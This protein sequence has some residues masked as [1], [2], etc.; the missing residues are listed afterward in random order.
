MKKLL[1]VALV[2]CMVT[3][4]L[5]V[6][7]LAD[8]EISVTGVTV[9]GAVGAT[10]VMNGE[11]LQMIATVH[12]DNAS[13]KTV[14]WW[15][16]GNTGSA[17]ISSTGLLTAVSPGTVTVWAQCT[18]RMDSIVITIDP[19]TATS[20]TITGAGS[21][22]SVANGYTLQMSAEVLP[23]LTTNK[24]VSWTLNPGTGSATING[25]T[26]LLKGTGLGTVTVVANT[27]VVPYVAGY[28][29]VTVTEP[30]KVSGVTVTGAGD[31]ASVV[32]YCTLQM[33]AAVLPADATDKSCTWSVTDSGGTGATINSTGLLTAGSA[34]TVTVKA[35]AND[36]S[37]VSGELA[38]TVTADA[39]EPTLS[40]VSYDKLTSLGATL[41]FSAGEAGT[42][43]YL[44]YL[45]SAAAPDAA[46]IKS[47]GTSGAASAGDNSFA[48]NTLSPATAY[49]VYIALKDAAGN[50]SDSQS[51]SFT[52]NAAPLISTAGK[53][54][55]VY[56]KN[57][58]G[59]SHRDIVFT[60]ALNGQTFSGITGLTEGTNYTVS[61]GT[62]TATVTLLSSYLDGLTLWLDHD[63]N[64]TFTFGDG[65]TVTQTYYVY[66]TCYEKVSPMNALWPHAV[67]VDSAGNLYYS[68]RAGIVIEYTAYD[69]TQWGIDMKA[70]YSYIIAQKNA[71]GFA[72]DEAGNLYISSPYRL[73]HV[74][75]SDHSIYELA[76]ADHTQW[77]ITMVAGEIYRIAGTGA[78]GFSGDGGAAAAAQFN[79][80]QGIDVDTSGNV[81][82]CDM[83]NNRVRMIAASTGTYFG[84]PMTAG[85]IYTVAGTGSTTFSGL[86]PQP[87][88]VDSFFEPMGVAVDQSGNIY[89]TSAG[90][91][92]SVREVAATVHTQWGYTDMQVGYS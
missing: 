31:A 54:G 69:H 18:D 92:I 57:S 49:T 28:L 47:A 42:Y 67:E 72:F 79:S 14:Y 11:T 76:A 64:L 43:Y 52:T 20:V 71:G 81:Y 17:T 27:T 12:P 91:S 61:A 5:P 80:P 15:I 50:I 86:D 4:L 70:G 90:N 63:K 62:D 3:A 75:Y 58:R 1:S 22:K 48:I 23:E 55:N 74:D 34:G 10:S 21:A 88:T 13:I 8:D 25:T 45:A 16:V 84:I 66:N 59:G 46:M 78:E 87:A 7:A 35:T 32:N 24:T 2:L 33:S 60:V 89:I 9:T 41:K 82:I 56:D 77:G 6:T 65:S 73:G 38:V 39:D 85:Y 68:D 83:E 30:V 26:G 40:S 53:F 37:L 19:V 36:G 29:E 44:A 51:I